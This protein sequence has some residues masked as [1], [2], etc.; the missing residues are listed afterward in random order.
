MFHNTK[1]NAKPESIA[2]KL[3][4]QSNEEVTAF[5]NQC[6][7]QKLEKTVKFI[8]KKLIPIHE[9]VFKQFEDFCM[10]KIGGATRE[11]AKEKLMQIAKDGNLNSVMNSSDFS[12]MFSRH[13]MELM[14]VNS[15]PARRNAVIDAAKKYAD[16]RQEYDDVQRVLGIIKP[17]SDSRNVHEQSH[18]HSCILM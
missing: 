14:M 3:V 10:Q 7:P 15:E 2:Y 9:K 12:S 6:D 1:D 18:H 16:A 4:K 5:A 13:G 11:E 8:T 17:I